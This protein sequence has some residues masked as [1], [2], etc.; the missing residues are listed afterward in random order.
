[1]SEPTLNAL[2]LA[3]GLAV[4]WVDANGRPQTVAPDVLVNVLE[5]LGHPCHSREAIAD[6][7]HELTQATHLP[8]LLTAEQFQPLN[9]DGY[10]PAGAAYQVQLEDGTTRHGQLD[11]LAHLPGQLPMGY[12]RLQIG[13]SA[14]TLAVAPAQCYALQ[15]VTG[16]AH[17]RRWG[18]SAQLYALR[19]EGDGGLGDTLALQQLVRSAAV[20]GADAVAISPVHAMFSADPQRFSPYSPSS[21]LFLNPLHCAPGTVLGDEPLRAAIAATGLQAELTRLEDLE[22]IDW[23]AATQA[24]QQVLRQL[25]QGFAAAPA[26]LR[27][28]FQAFRQRGGE[29]LENHCRFEALHAMF[30]RDSGPR[31]WQSW[32]QPYRD[33]A[34]AE[35]ARFAEQQVNEIAYHAFAQWLIDCGLAQAQQAARDAGMGIGLI[36]DLAV[37]ADGGG[38]Q[39]WSRQDE[40]L[41]SLS[42]GAPPDIL[43]RRGQGWGV[44]AFSPE[45]LRRNGFRAFIEMLR[46][47]FAHAGGVRIDHVM[48]LMRLWLIPTGAEPHQGAYLHYPL[49]DLLHL[50]ALESWRHRAVVVG[51]DLGTV[52]DGFRELLEDRRILGMRV[53]QFEQDHQGQFKPARSWPESALATTATHD[54]PTMAGW[55]RGR[56]LEWQTRLG[57]TPEEHRESD[58]LAREHNREALR[59]ALLADQGQSPDTLLDTE[60]ALDACQAFVGHTPAPLILAPLE[61]LLGAEEQANVPG[62][63]DSH[64]NWR[65]RWTRSS[66]E[67][68]ETKAVQRR[69]ALLR[70]ARQ[71]A[72]PDPEGHA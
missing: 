54:L 45:G 3:A 47:N 37:G 13:A 63:I 58:A 59:Q 66:P 14:L 25:Y 61:D 51:E 21:R 27:A 65:R 64:P 29:A 15:D 33:P 26:A 69:L 31:G 12:H 5:G 38:S 40:L 42:V 67:L 52:P 70:Q 8:P 53:L 6:A 35:V 11:H 32:P 68:L 2:A 23:P 36:A 46:A 50:L 39:A 55:W 19:R 1:M 34:S 60:A 20:Q 71:A 48:G 62:T 9:L 49:Q 4:D 72:L 41:G 56:D 18:L 24:K 30:A 17:P 7:L 28:Q 16:Q 22:L 43:N 10:F 44:S 57:L